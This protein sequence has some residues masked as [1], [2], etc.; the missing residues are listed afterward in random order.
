MSLLLITLAE[1]GVTATNSA[2]SELILSGL[3]TLHQR[4]SVPMQIHG[5]QAVAH[6]FQWLT[7]WLIPS[8]WIQSIST[9]PRSESRLVISSISKSAIQLH[10]GAQLRVN[11][12]SDQHNRATTEFCIEC[13]ASFVA[14]QPL[15]ANTICPDCHWPIFAPSEI[16]FSQL[17]LAQTRITTPLVAL[18][19]DE[20]D[21]DFLEDV[22]ATQR[23]LA[24][25]FL[26]HIRIVCC[27]RKNAPEA[28]STRAV[29][30]LPTVIIF[31]GFNERHRIAGIDWVLLE[32]VLYFTLGWNY[33][34]FLPFETVNSSQEND[35]PPTPIEL[36]LASEGVV[37]RL[38]VL[39][40]RFGISIEGLYVKWTAGTNS[41]LTV[42]GE[43]R[44]AT[45]PGLQ[46][47]FDL[48]ADC[49][50]EHGRVVEHT[51][52]AYCRKDNF[53][54]FATWHQVFYFNT[55]EDAQSIRRVRIYPRAR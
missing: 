31:D 52:L 22:R 30:Y 43:I 33:P 46:S 16:S 34:A 48:I 12:E 44:S 26:G 19:Y 13:G 6:N 29:A 17:E 9:D 55:V 36:G 41:S 21:E 25:K 37:E 28:V 3:N 49:I 54:G 18:L 27:S 40:D 2:P 50:D 1:G 24:K 39:E 5:R 42:N 4:F 47:D 51:T 20:N 11:T 14:L 53:F 45:G 32:R 7:V 8:L 38:E 10:R 15:E 35:G 23:L